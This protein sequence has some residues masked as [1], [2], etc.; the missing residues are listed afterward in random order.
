[1]SYNIRFGVEEVDYEELNRRIPGVNLNVACT[2][3]RGAGEGF[4]G[5]PTSIC[6]V[7]DNLSRWNYI[8]WHVGLQ[9]RE[10]RSPGK[11]SLV[12]VV[13][14]G[15]GGRMQR[16]RSRYARILFHLLLVHHDC[17]ESLQ[18]D[19]VL[20]EGSGLGEYRQ[21]VVWAL[22]DNTSLRT[23]TL[24]SL[25]DDYGSIRGDLLEA[26]SSM[27]NLRELI[28]PGRSA[29]PPVLLDA[30]CPLLIDTLCLAT[31]SM[32]GIVFDEESS[33][34]LTDALMNND[35]VEDLS[36]HVSILHSYMP[37]GISSFS[38]FLAT[39][40]LLTSL[41][42]EGV[43]SDPESA[44]ADLKSIVRPLVRRGE[45]EQLRLAGFLLNTECAALLAQLVSLKEGCLRSL[46]I[47]GCQWWVSKSL[48]VRRKADRATRDEQL[49][50]RAFRKSMCSW[51]HAFD[52]TGRVELTFF[53]LSLEGLEPED[54]LALFNIA[55]TVESLQTISLRNVSRYH[56]AQVCRIIQQTGM[57]GRVRLEDGYLVDSSA[58]AR[59]REFPEALRKIAI[60]SVDC[61]SPKTFV[62]AVQ[63][64]CSWYKVT[65]LKLLLTQ[66]VLSDIPT[67]HKLS[68]CL[69]NAFW[70]SELVLIGYKRP[71][72][73]LTLKSRDPPHSVLLDVISLNMSLRALRLSGI[74]LGEDNLRFLVDKIV[75]TE[76]L[77]E[78]SFASWD[79]TENDNF[80]RFLVERFHANNSVTKLHVRVSANRA[81]DERWF[82]VED[83]VSR[84]TGY[85]TC[86][87]HYLLGDQS[88][89]SE[90]AFK[91]LCN[92]PALKNKRDELRNGG[93]TRGTTRNI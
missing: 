6:H 40:E 8:L 58:L 14:R 31:L 84:N 46:D 83:V 76:T 16:V 91:T 11:L 5:F 19:D 75:A 33:M 39:S 61:A 79:P 42:V 28:I 7:F 1:M 55:V 56:L 89:R 66:E 87:A 27:T 78:F 65:T 12:S 54:L 35:T 72:L 81:E 24:S 32:P 71:D 88:P 38:R 80:F 10:L 67:F 90:A 30:L 18:L 68:K 74:R 53:A 43:H 92:A 17:V 77:S 3:R 36:V 29:A 70:L 9:L 52:R 26:I 15:G 4:R 73:D 50:D 23:L 2:A 13:Y 60:S 20:I 22:E 85:L 34:R 82:F 21:F 57:S 51:L 59:L 49:D 41:S 45:L 48:P 44:F 62:D 37:N 93:V 25:F 64:S 86:A 47:S 63:L 69:K